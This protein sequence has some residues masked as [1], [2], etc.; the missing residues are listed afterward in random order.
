V[1][2]LPGAEDAAGSGVSILVSASS[3]GSRLSESGVGLHPASTSASVKPVIKL[4]REEAM[5]TSLIRNNRVIIIVAQIRP[6][7]NPTR[8][9]KCAP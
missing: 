9:W 1:L 5:F 6:I 8:A 3:G 7:F 4:K 2:L